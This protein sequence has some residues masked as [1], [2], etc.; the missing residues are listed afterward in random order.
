[1]TAGQVDGKRPSNTA[2]AVTDLR[3]LI[4]SGELPA[5]SD[6]L[7]SELAV[8]LGMSRT[9]VR[10]AALLLE[11]QG[12]VAL[13]PRKGVRILPIAPDDMREIYDVLS[14][15][16]CLAVTTAA[17]RKPDS[18]AL[19]PLAKALREMDQTLGRD[20]LEGWAV[21]DEAFHRALVRLGGNSR[22]MGV[23]AMMNDQVR[24]ARSVTL[25]MRPRPDASNADHRAVLHAIRD[26]APERAAALHR[27]HRQEAK[28][29][30]ISLLEKHKLSRI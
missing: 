3:A 27:A 17:A 30:I 14:E 20:D 24:R 26:G 22:A 1:M 23:A 25:H 2:R 28:E 19:A 16:E 8:R 29:M 21:A 13:R 18:K 15:L 10:E 6:H 9:P 4:F 12:L 7:E 5:G 11:S